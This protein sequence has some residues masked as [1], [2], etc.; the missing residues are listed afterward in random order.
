MI[1]MLRADGTDAPERLFQLSAL[2]EVSRIIE[3]RD[4][5]S[6]LVFDV[7]TT[8]IGL[9]GARW[10][11]AW[12][13][14][15]LGSTGGTVQ[16][17][18]L[19]TRRGEAILSRA[20]LDR[21]AGGS[22]PIRLDGGDQLA[23]A[24]EEG[25]PS[26]LADQLPELILPLAAGDHLR[27]L[28]ALGSNFLDRPYESFMLHLL[29]SISYLTALAIGDHLPLPERQ[30]ALSGTGEDL[31]K[32]HPPLGAIVGTS[33]QVQEVCRHLVTV[34]DAA[35]TV[36][37][38]GET[39]TG[40]QLAAEVLHALGPRAEGPFV[41]VDCGAI[42]DTLIEDEL[43][44]HT[45][46]AFTGASEKRQGVFRLAD[47]GTLF[48]DE[49]ASLPLMTQARLLR[50]LQE[51]RF[52]PLGGS[53]TVEV[54]VR[55]V[56]ASNADLYRA[57][58]QGTFR[59][60]L[61]YRL[62]VY[63]IRIPPLRERPEDIIPLA[64]HFAQR[65]AEENRRPV[66]DLDEAFLKRLQVHGFPGNV[67]E[68][69][70]LMER[71]LLLAGGRDVLDEAILL[72]ALRGPQGAGWRIQRE[73]GSDSSD[74]A[75]AAEGDWPAAPRSRGQWVLNVLREHDYNIRAASEDLAMAAEAE[76]SR[77]VVF[78]RRAL[79]YYFQAECFRLY[80]E[81][82]CRVEETARYLTSHKP[83][84]ERSIASRLKRYLDTAEGSISGART[85]DEA[86]ARLREQFERIP[87][88]YQPV[89]ERLAD[90]L[91]SRPAPF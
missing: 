6:Q 76:G 18:G 59:E 86:R 24:V 68:L 71:S 74:R 90:D 72:E 12:T 17:C 53:Q 43:F 65:F 15:A 52:R 29:D 89:L 21:L 80:V 34:A 36:L 37:L 28:M 16:A 50:V 78:D 54:D 10:G 75:A 83:K 38:E 33:S 49:I 7:L 55:V 82:G 41:E 19:A 66:P 11:V 48:L 2:Y 81:R 44:G 40:K 88:P 1:E 60:D 62:Y 13:P 35:C 79:T 87:A 8:V 25:L 58:Q 14:D 64:R 22:R 39:G 5:S 46:G 26:W 4:G 3:E 57:V 56:A 47:G 85:R 31:R 9:T 63:P 84:L 45:R 51:R 69:M 30:K 23:R 20:W 77:P 73:E 27:G 70:H 67:R 91:W 32:G 61:F 42:P